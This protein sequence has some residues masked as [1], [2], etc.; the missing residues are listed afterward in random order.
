MEKSGRVIDIKPK[1]VIVEVAFSVQLKK[2]VEQILKTKI[3]ED[4]KNG[5]NNS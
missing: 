5:R 3:S 2:A 1:D 4:E